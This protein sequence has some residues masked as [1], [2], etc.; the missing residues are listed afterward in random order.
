MLD[1]SFD[2]L[3]YD[4]NR[5]FHLTNSPAMDILI[6]SNLERLLYLAVNNDEQVVS[7]LMNDL[8]ET[9]K[10]TLPIEYKEALSDFMAYSINKEDTVKYI[11]KVYE[12]NKYLIDPHTAVAYGAYDTLKDKLNGKTVIASTASPYK[13]LE[14]VDEIFKTNKDGIEQVKAIEKETGCLAPKVLYDIYSTPFEKVV[15]SKDEMEE[16]L[17]KLIG[18]LDENC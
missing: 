9:G 1:G 3:T 17:I 15:W 10:Y 7:K 11:E 13:F 5:S 18:E 8:K 4:K 6:S 12:E 2:T 14:T 16:Q